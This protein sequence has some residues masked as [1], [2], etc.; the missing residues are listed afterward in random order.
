MTPRI[1]SLLAAGALAGCATGPDYQRPETLV[2]HAWPDE[3]LFSAEPQD[4]WSEWWRRFGDPS[5]NELVGRALD[6]NLEIQLQTARVQEFRA[7]LGYARAERLPS[8]YAQ[9]GASRERI[10]G[11]AIG[12]PPEINP[13]T[14]NLFS[15]AGLLEYEVDLWG[16]VSR[17]REA[18]DALFQESGFA[19]DAVRLSVTAD[20]V[21][22]YFDL[23]TAES[24]LAITRATIASRE[25]TLRLQEIRREGGEIDELTLQQARS[26]LESAR[27]SLPAFLQRK[28]I[29]EG[30]LG[31]L[32]G[33][34]P[35]ELWDNLE[36]QGG[37]LAT[38]QLPG[39]LPGFLP[40]ELLERRP[41][42]RAAEAQLMAATAGIG[43]SRAERLP[44]VNLSALL[45]TAAAST[46]DL[47]TGAAET[48]RLGAA[49]AGP[50]WDF[51]RS[52]ARV[53]SATALAEQAEVRYRLTV[54]GAFNDVRN[55]LVFYET[56]QDRT[57]SSRRL[58][59]S[60]ER[61]ER[62][63][64]LR[65]QEGFISFLEYLDAQ[66]ALLSARL[67]LEE[68][69]RDHLVAAASLFKALG[70]GWQG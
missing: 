29:L 64:E 25:E 34:E 21:T 56:S 26:E 66:R 13:G 70:G 23:R 65:Y 27:A 32:V 10:S 22:T 60:L 38:L 48:W 15:V 37:D 33:L 40:A 28:R 69:V 58:V 11:A 14:R 4:D 61:T 8:L 46:G 51:G 44:R 47:F 63:A 2:P 49:V 19:R 7:R 55:A 68:A 3:E 16:R 42:V 52:A 6:R 62:L 20:L 36:W 41:D 1:L 30:A 18:A 17:E 5:L 12:L 67:A 50:L 59:E 31:I 24:Q 53:E 45:G 39:Q 9:A 43:V 57:E 54:Q 35:A